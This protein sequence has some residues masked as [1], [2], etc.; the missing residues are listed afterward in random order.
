MRYEW[1][2]TV[3]LFSYLINVATP[4]AFKT[5]NCKPNDQT[6]TRFDPHWLHVTS[7]FTR[8]RDPV[9]SSDQNKFYYDEDD[10]LWR[11]GDGEIFEEKFSGA[12]VLK[13]ICEF[14]K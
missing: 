7:T 8:S 9:R 11:F 4:R 5:R 2:S 6:T 13:N 12:N 3:L 1:L 10:I 14:C